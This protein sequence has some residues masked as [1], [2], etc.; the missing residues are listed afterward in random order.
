MNSHSVP[1][2]MHPSLRLEVSTQILHH[3]QHFWDL[4]VPLTRRPESHQWAEYSALRPAFPFFE[5]PPAEIQN[6]PRIQMALTPAEV[7]E[8][9]RVLSANNIDPAGKNFD[10]SGALNAAVLGGD[11]VIVRLLL[12]GFSSKAKRSALKF[13][14]KKFTNMTTVHVDTVGTGGYTPLQWASALGFPTIV[15]I[16][17]EHGASA[18]KRIPGQ[19][20]I[21]EQEDHYHGQTALEVAIGCGQERVVETFCSVTM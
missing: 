5:T 2:S 15:R 20:G 7:E 12:Q 3:H 16:L 14:S 8:A 9:L 4:R 11:E 1:M 6:L 21:F 18:S 17:L 10:K 19:A 13:G